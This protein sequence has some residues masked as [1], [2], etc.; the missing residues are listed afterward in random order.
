MAYVDDATDI[1]PSS[2][3]RHAIHPVLMD[4]I[5]IIGALQTAIL[6]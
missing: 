2:P 3:A 1:Y 6:I 5:Y 4:G